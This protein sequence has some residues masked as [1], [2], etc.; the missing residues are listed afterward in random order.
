[1]TMSSSESDDE[2]SA[3]LKEAVSEELKAFMMP[4]S[5]SAENLLNSK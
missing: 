1:M 2:I 3:N 5:T 4:Q